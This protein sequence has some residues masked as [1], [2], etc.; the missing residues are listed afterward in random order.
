M[1]GRLSL[2]ETD[3][4]LIL[5][6]W[7]RYDDSLFADE[8][9]E[10]LKQPPKSHSELKGARIRTEAPRFQV[11]DSFHCFKPAFQGF[12]TFLTEKQQPH[13]ETA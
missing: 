13:S 10:M 11:Q 7:A 1:P 4:I 6:L 9:K 3:L 8:E 5:S 12:C 2:R